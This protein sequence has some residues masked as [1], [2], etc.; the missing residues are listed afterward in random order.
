[1]EAT[2]KDDERESLAVSVPAAGR[3][4]GLGRNAAYQA[5]KRGD[6]PTL[7]LGRRIVVPLDPLRKKLAES[8][9]QHRVRDDGHPK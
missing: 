9:D 1:M 3:M 6:L 4:L 5:A 2:L 8:G 7:R